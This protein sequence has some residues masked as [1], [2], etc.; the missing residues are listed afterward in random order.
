MPLPLKPHQLSEHPVAAPRAPGR[1]RALMRL[2]RSSAS[3]AEARSPQSR[4]PGAYALLSGNFGP[5]ER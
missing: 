4:R 5:R 3:G 1:W 2:F